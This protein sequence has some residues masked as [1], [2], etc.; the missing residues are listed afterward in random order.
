MPRPILQRCDVCKRY[1]AWYVV[2]DAEFG[3][4]HLCT[5]CWNALYGGST[6]SEMDGKSGKPK[7]PMKK[8]QPGPKS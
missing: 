7:P 1:H 3:T 8:D 2:E 5:N 6:H 4:R